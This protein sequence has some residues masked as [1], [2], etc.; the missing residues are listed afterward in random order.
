MMRI[1]DERHVY[2]GDEPELFEHIEGLMFAGDTELELEGVLY[3]IARD[4]GDR[5]EFYV[6]TP[7]S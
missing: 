4:R 3:T 6:L 5:G 1:G 2:Q 7:E